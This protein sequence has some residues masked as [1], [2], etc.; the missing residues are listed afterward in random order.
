GANTGEVLFYN[1]NKGGMMIGKV[2]VDGTF[3]YV[4]QN[5]GFGSGWSNFAGGSNGPMLGYVKYN[6]NGATYNVNPDGTLVQLKSYTTFAR[7]WTDITPA[8]HGILI[9]SRNDG[10]DVAMGLTQYTGDFSTLHSYAFMPAAG[11]GWSSVAAM[12]NDSV[13]FYDT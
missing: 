8:N 2:L 6:G 7:F 10:P 5:I 9:F 13:L 1:A 4:K 11:R 3:T 12:S